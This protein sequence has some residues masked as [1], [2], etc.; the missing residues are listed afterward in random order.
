LS[1]VARLRSALVFCRSAAL[2]EY[3]GF[4]D[5]HYYIMEGRNPSAL[6]LL[7]DSDT[8]STVGEGLSNLARECDRSDSPAKRSAG[9]RLRASRIGLLDAFSPAIQ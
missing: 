7:S 8:R 5:L 4:P 1:A 6:H 2:A 3:G 9:R